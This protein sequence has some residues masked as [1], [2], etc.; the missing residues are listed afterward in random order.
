MDEVEEHRALSLVQAILEQEFSHLEVK[1][2]VERSPGFLIEL[3]EVYRQH[4][5]VLAGRTPD[6]G[7]FGVWVVLDEVRR[8]LGV[9]RSCM[10]ING[11]REVCA[12]DRKSCGKVLVGASTRVAGI[13]R[14]SG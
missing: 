6:R 8:S 7:D 1:A 12:S 5:L 9:I 11:E 3:G 4:M 10:P 14:S 13:T 2:S